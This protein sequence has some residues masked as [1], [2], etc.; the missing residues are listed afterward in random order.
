MTRENAFTLSQV[1]GLEIQTRPL[2][3]FAATRVLTGKP[4][5][6]EAEGLAT[7]SQSQPKIWVEWHQQQ[8]VPFDY[9]EFY[10][11]G[12]VASVHCDHYSRP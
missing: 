10:V 2:P 1:R 12:P 11:S 7:S 8:T 4:W 3:R 9:A 5:D 6:F